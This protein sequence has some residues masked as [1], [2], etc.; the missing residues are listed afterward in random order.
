[1]PPSYGSGLLIGADVRA[2]LR[3]G[4]DAEI[5]VMGRP[6]LTRLYAEGLRI[7]GSSAARWTEG[8]SVPRRCKRDRGADRMS[9]VEDFAAISRNARWSRSSAA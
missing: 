5:F 7:A 2:G 6:E 8:A 9:A 1:M 3:E 4:A